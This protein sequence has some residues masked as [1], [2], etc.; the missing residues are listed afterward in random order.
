M[1]HETTVHRV[2][3]QY[4][5]DVAVTT[6]PE[7]VAVDGTDEVLRLW[8]GH[9][10]KVLG[11]SGTRTSSVLV[12]TLDRAWTATVD[13]D[14][15]AV[16]ETLA[17]TRRTDATVSAPPMQLYLWLWGRVSVHHAQLRGDQD[18]I[19][20]LWALLRLATR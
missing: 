6:V 12:R 16:R 20:Q 3:V 10:A 17:G 8:F 14:G 1:C 15:T 18:A 2:D 7:D 9:R 19:A 13:R 4:A 11:L 5:R